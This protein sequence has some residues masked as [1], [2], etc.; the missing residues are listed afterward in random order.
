MSITT[1]AINATLTASWSRVADIINESLVTDLGLASSVTSN[2]NISISA[3]GIAITIR[4]NANTYVVDVTVGSNSGSWVSGDTMF[5]YLRSVITCSNGLLMDFVTGTSTVYRSAIIFTKTN[6]NKLG[7]IWCLPAD[8]LYV[9]NIAEAAPGDEIVVSSPVVYAPTISS[10]QKSAL[11]QTSLTPFLFW[12][13]SN[14][15]SYAQCASYSVR[16]VDVS[17][18]F[19]D[20]ILGNYHYVS[21]GFIW[22]KDDPV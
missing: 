10:I 11:V 3:T 2:N 6:T 1:H 17:E 5:G 13:G 20:Y 22:L 9:L 16:P 18:K 12:P 8:D 14:E 4:P 7:V 21:N 15:V 19:G